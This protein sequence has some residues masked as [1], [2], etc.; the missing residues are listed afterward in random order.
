MARHWFP[1]V[2]LL[3]G[4]I[5][6]ETDVAGAMTVELE[7]R[8]DD[9]GFFARAWCKR[10]FEAHLLDPNL[11]QANLVMT[12]QQGTVRGLH[13]Q[14]SPYEEAKLIRCIKG[15]I[16]DV[17]VDLR[18]G[19]PTYL[20]WVGVELSAENY[21]MMYVPRGCAHGYQTL[22][23]CAETLYHVSEFFA[24]EAERGVRYDD[25]AFGIKW[26]LPVTAV[27]EKDKRWPDY[28]RAS[29][30]VTPTQGVSH[31]HR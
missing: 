7:K 21:R 13:Y 8:E 5:F 24:P 31:G 28:V 6:L 22:T 16:F 26:P 20:Q 30:D 2:G 3:A 4:M 9:R 17:V 11:V 25:P 27:S 1:S 18:P 10:E 14:V 19:S 29:S 12:K 23:D 15:K